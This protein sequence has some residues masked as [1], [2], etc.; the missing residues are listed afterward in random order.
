M[1]VIPSQM[2][3]QNLTF[4][5]QGQFSQSVTKISPDI[6]INTLF[7]VL[8]C[9]NY[10]ILAILIRFRGL[11]L[12]HPFFIIFSLVLEP[13]PQ[14]FGHKKARFFAISMVLYSL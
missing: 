10:V 2:P 4:F 13:D 14:A 8:G 5:L 12:F 11:S 6:S 9:S 3:F 1:K 7:Q